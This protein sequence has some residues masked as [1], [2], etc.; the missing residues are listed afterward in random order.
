M[1]QTPDY[2]TSLGGG[3]AYYNR[4]NYKG[5][6][7]RANQYNNMRNFGNRPNAGGGA[8]YMSTI[9]N[10][11]RPTTAAKSNPNAFANARA[12]M[13]SPA[14]YGDEEEGGIME[15]IKEKGGNFLNDANTMG[16]NF[17]T[18]MMAA[19]KRVLEGIGGMSEGIGRGIR[20]HNAYKDKYGNSDQYNADKKAMMTGKDRAFYNKYMNLAEL[21]SD[22][23]KARQ[24]RETADTAWRNQQTTD[25]L[26]FANQF[27]GYAPGKY[28]GQGE[29]SRY[30]GGYREG[31]LVPGYDRMT[32]IINRN[33]IENPR[34]TPQGIQYEDPDMLN[35]ILPGEP[36]VDLRQYAGMETG[37]DY[38]AMGLAPDPEN[39]LLSGEPG[40]G[41]SDIVPK[42][43]PIPDED[44]DFYNYPDEKYGAPLRDIDM[45]EGIYQSP[46]ADTLYN[47]ELVAASPNPRLR[48]NPAFMK[49]RDTVAI[50]S[51]GGGMNAFDSRRP[52]LFEYLPFYSGFGDF[53]FSPELEE[54]DVVLGDGSIVNSR[55]DLY[56]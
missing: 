53:N 33:F 26:A 23:D 15:V 45:Y 52:G 6:A 19:G 28:T 40:F 44:A 16:S 11:N 38:D 39:D 37:I 12:L 1:T 5:D 49:P 25:R 50:E 43:K 21:T 55:L 34:A 54:D 35:E 47:E 36:G 41:G 31:D 27:E 7:Y 14:A 22:P 56:N 30:T 48:N 24:Y 3:D 13:T 42:I 20:L 18:P 17:A 4:P 8:D 46:L 10:I 29:G 2:N 9:G 32:E 51:I